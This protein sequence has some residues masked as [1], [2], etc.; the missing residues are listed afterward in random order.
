M[1]RIEGVRQQ[2]ALLA[3]LVLIVYAN[4][5]DGGFHFDD[6]HSV[7]RN[8][9]IRTLAAVPT[10]FVDGGTFSAD[11]DVSM[12]RPLLL[13]TYAL[14]YAL[15]GGDP[16]GYHLVNVLCHIAFVLLV[17]LVGRRLTGRTVPMWWAAAML[18][19]HPLNSQAV[20]YVSSRS[21]ILAAV[22][23]LAALYLGT[24]VSQPRLLWAGVSQ[25]AALLA[26]STA[27]AGA[28]LTALMQVGRP[29]RGHMGAVVAS[30]TACVAYVGASWHSGFYGTAL[31][32]FIRPMA[33]QVPTQ[34]KALAY[35]I[36]LSIC[37]VR[38][39][40]SHPFFESSAP[41]PA[42]VASALLTLTL[43]CLGGLA[44]QRRNLAGFGLLWFYGGLAITSV[45]PLY[46]LVS[47]QRVY[48][49][50]A[51]LTIAGAQL[52]RTLP[53]TV[54]IVGLATLA[55]LTVQ[56]NAVW[57]DELGLWTDA[58]RLAPTEARVWAGLGEA[59]Y[60]LGEADSAAVAYDR[61]IELRPEA[62]TPWNNLGVVYEEAG[63]TKQAEDAFRK[64]LSLRPG[65]PEAQAN[66][67]RLLL[68]SGRAAEARPLLGRSAA[69]SPSA[70]V[71]VNLGVAA[72]RVGEMDLAAKAFADALDLEHGHVDAQV[73]LAALRLDQALNMAASAEQTRWLQDA[74][75]LSRAVLEAAG[76][77]ENLTA[78]LNLAAVAAA[79]GRR[80]EAGRQY[81]EILRL[82]PESALAHEGY[83]RL[84]LNVGNPRAAD[85]LRRGIE[86]GEVGVHQELAGSGPGRS[87]P[88]T[89]GGGHRCVRRGG[90]SQSRGSGAALQPGRDQLPALAGDAVG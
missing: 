5:L 10:Y 85:V 87:H 43:L 31:D 48:L 59:W 77:E 47:E 79:Q 63:H 56:R 57:Q 86:L 72:A 37:P 13:V 42:V 28:G 30:L 6:H 21:G 7:E 67:G 64:A 8:T 16:F 66:L 15:G 29:G 9:A 24:V 3:I 70:G 40:I 46:V 18:A 54:V 22:G 44:W 65:W 61:A 89:L 90:R 68:H 26:K 23:A 12:Y 41:E 84:L 32:G 39:S 2:C 34:F 49:S 82:E 19:V 33:T 50:L 1:L 80:K 73:N 11:P 4:S 88:R 60:D 55:T 83:G 53:R 38:L 17:F 76:E 45:V 81:E 71:L 75:H 69:R 27:I 36:Y 14:N 58:A 78:R 52:W 62:E 74:E 35:Y 51:G 25:F 20:N